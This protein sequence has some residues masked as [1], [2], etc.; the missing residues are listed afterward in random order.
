MII[1]KFIFVKI[2]IN[3]KKILIFC[4][5][6]GK[7]MK[8]NLFYLFLVE[9]V[10]CTMVWSL[11]FFG[12]LYFLWFLFVEYDILDILRIIVL[13]D[14]FGVCMIKCIKGEVL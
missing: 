3:L 11:I 1:K 7:S 13:R 9:F 12:E 6:R 4:N 5:I 10:L 8:I 14:N 2:I